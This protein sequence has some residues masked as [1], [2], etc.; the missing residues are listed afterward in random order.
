M[1]ELIKGKIVKK[2]QNSGM[3]FIRGE[4][5]QRYV[6]FESETDIKVKE[7]KVVCFRPGAPDIFPDGTMAKLPRAHDIQG[8]PLWKTFNDPELR[9]AVTEYYEWHGSRRIHLYKI[10][11]N[12]KSGYQ[13]LVVHFIDDQENRL[14]SL[15]EFQPWKD[16]HYDVTEAET[17]PRDQ[18]EKMVEEFVNSQ[19]YL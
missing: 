9:K 13:M 19:E 16:G 14:T 12:K 4:D 8:D 6:G 11:V 5:G 2:R 7:G 10:A 17:C 1:S 18:E 3:L 15:M